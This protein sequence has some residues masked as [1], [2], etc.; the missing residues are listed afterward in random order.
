MKTK[1]VV[2]PWFVLVVGL[3]GCTTLSQQR[4][5]DDMRRLSELQEIRSRLDRVEAR[6]NGIVEGQEQLAGEV[7]ALR[8]E[9]ATASGDSS[10][11]LA[12]LEQKV[13]AQAEES[14]RARD[15]LLGTVTTRVAEIVNAPPASARAGA[16][17]G[18]EHSVQ[19]GETLSEIA[20]AYGVTVSAIVKA[21][22]LTN[23]DTIRVGQKLFI[24]Q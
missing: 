20:K 12:M 13:A 4:Q 10:R 14:A 2:L 18:L 11:R 5:Y 16:E 7:M 19:Q 1:S 3:S 17:T 8:S 9:G 22:G 6:I 15:V 21:N 24:P 23:A